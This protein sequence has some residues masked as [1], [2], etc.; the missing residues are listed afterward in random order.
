MAL[1]SQKGG[2]LA[3]ELGFSPNERTQV[4]TAISEVAGNLWLYAGRGSVEL[5]AVNEAERVGITVI[6]RDAG[7]GI[8]DVEQALRDGYSTSG[9]MGLGMPGAMRLMDDFDVASELGRGTTVTM[10]RWRRKPG[11]PA[12]QRPSVEWAASPSGDDVRALFCPFPNG[13]LIAACAGLGGGEEASRAAATAASL[14]ESRPSESPVTLVQRCHEALRGTRGAALAIASFSEL[15]A[16][17]TWLSIGRVEAVLLRAAPGDQP[18]SEAAPAHQGVVGLRLP[19]LQAST[20]LV[21]R[22]DRLVMSSGSTMLGKARFLRGVGE[23]R[24]PA[25]R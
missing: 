21:R 14:L 16:W 10:T 18:M 4:V 22:D 19:A 9:G 13:V 8:A 12:Q 6:A 7:P 24:P 3:V 1:A 2:A 25:A 11:A 5:G 23:R 20:A 15:D 17:M